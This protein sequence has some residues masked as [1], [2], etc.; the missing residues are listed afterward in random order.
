MI[1][2]QKNLEINKGKKEPDMDILSAIITN[3]NDLF[4]NI[5]WSDVDNIRR[6]IEELPKMVLK[7]EKYQNAIKNSDKQNARL[8]SE[9]ALQNVMF[10]IMSDNM[11]LFK[12]FTDDQLFKKWLSDMVFN[13]TYEDKAR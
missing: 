1:D 2:L 3:F 13:I 7:D 8:E 11:E 12:Q 10:N 4:G 9:R 6:Q 5:E